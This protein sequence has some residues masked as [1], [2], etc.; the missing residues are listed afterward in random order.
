MNKT[1]KSIW[2]E[3]LGTWV[4]VSELANARGKASK[5]C[6]LG[7]RAAQQPGKVKLVA[8]GVA[9]TFAMGLQGNAAWAGAL[10]NC[11]GTLNTGS[12]SSSN[13]NGASGSSTSAQFGWWQAT[14]WSANEGNCGTGT[15]IILSENGSGNGGL[16]GTSA[17]MLVGGTGANAAGVI[18]LYGPSGISLKDVTS[19]NN[20]KIT[21]LAAG[22]VSAASTDAVNGS[23]LSSL[24]TSASTGISTAQSG[25]TSLSTG[26]STTNSSV[27]SLSTGLSATN[28]NVVSLSTSASSLEFDADIEVDVDIELE[29]RGNDHRQAVLDYLAERQF[30]VVD[31]LR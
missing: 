26:L 18:T 6:C 31:T 29:T 24:S 4:A 9:L 27:T 12:G 10:V 5:G 11:N 16:A 20:N 3:A 8:I 19:L 25:V 23:Q 1:Y 15:G 21:N 22:T 2:S 13:N 30:R 17:Y 14:N 28:S 7:V